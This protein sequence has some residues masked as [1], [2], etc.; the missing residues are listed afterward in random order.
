MKAGVECIRVDCYICP[1]GNAG[2]GK[3]ASPHIIGIKRSISNRGNFI[4]DGN[5]SQRILSK[6]PTSNGG[7]AV[8]DGNVGQ[9]V[10]RKRI[11]SNGGN[12]VPESN[13]G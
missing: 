13:A 7:N 11:V 6:C 10:V 3:T 8:G 2:Q 1:N 12:A 9:F 4:S 5:A